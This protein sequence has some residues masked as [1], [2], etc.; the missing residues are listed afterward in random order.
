MQQWKRGGGSAGVEVG[1]GAEGGVGAGVGA[2]AGGR[3]GDSAQRPMPHLGNFCGI[4][5]LRFVTLDLR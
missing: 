5:A 1:A 3:A 4:S 2:V